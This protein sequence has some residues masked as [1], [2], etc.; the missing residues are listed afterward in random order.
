MAVQSWHNK[1]RDIAHVNGP[2]IARAGGRPKADGP[3][4]LHP[5]FQS[6]TDTTLGAPP[7]DNNPP[8]ASS[9]L[10]TDPEK[11][12]GSKAFPK[13]AIHSSMT[14]TPHTDGGEQVLAGAVLSGSTKLPA[15]VSED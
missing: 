1:P 10:S 13:P 8:D 12:H 7:R 9:P 6:R 2:D 3:A 4:P 5:G 11:Q 14:A 15:T